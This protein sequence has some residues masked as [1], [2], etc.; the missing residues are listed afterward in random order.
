MVNLV[1]IE[2][3]FAPKGSYAHM[4]VK[5]NVE[6]ARNVAYVRTAMHDCFKRGEIPFASHA[7]YTLPGVLDD[8]VTEERVMGI[9]AGFKV[10]EVFSIVATML[11]FFFTFKRVFYID[12]GWSGGMKL[13][14]ADAREK[15]QKYEERTIGDRW[16][17]SKDV[18]YNVDVDGVPY[19]RR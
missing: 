9:Q 12:R 15:N 4:G 11:P 1:I 16:M 17:Q 2:S 13:G 7:L 19:D 14:L 5:P 10:C 6:L 3:P 8:T 18:H